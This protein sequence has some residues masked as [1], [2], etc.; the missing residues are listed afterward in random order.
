MCF[1]GV[2]SSRRVVGRKLPVFLCA[3]QHLRQLSIVINS[4]NNHAI[5]L[6][7][8][9]TVNRCDATLLRMEEEQAIVGT[10]KEP[11]L[12]L[13]ITLVSSVNINK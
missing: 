10:E 5:E 7:I 9:H 11:S 3:F 8:K 13:K 1:E 6:L 4:D 2:S 12:I